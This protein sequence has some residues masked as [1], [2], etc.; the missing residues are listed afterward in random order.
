MEIVGKMD[1]N[2]TPSSVEPVVRYLLE[3]S[4]QQA[5]L[6]QEIVMGLHSAMQELLTL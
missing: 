2:P 1:T 3:S 4:L 5:Q 6:K